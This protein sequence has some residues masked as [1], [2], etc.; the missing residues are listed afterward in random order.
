MQ[1]IYRAA[2]RV[3]ALLGAGKLGADGIR[4]DQD[5]WIGMASVF[6]DCLDVIHSVETAL[7]HHG[8]AQSGADCEPRC[9]EGNRHCEAETDQSRMRHIDDEGSEKSREMVLPSPSVHHKQ[10]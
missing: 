8:V 4:R 9:K 6:D 1:A 3:G 5:G 10:Y 7:G 2:V